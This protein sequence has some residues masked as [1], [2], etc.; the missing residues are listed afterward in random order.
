M[1]D[2]VWTY[3]GSHRN[4]VPEC[5]EKGELINITIDEN[6]GPCRHY[7]KR[8]DHNWS[9]WEL[10]TDDLESEYKQVQSRRVLLDAAHGGKVRTGQGSAKNNSGEVI[11]Q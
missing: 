11:F 4:Q 8:V 1:N 6:Q 2:P 9:P 3:V 10:F 7:L 5:E